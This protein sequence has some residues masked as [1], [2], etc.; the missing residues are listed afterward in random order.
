MCKSIRHH[1]ISRFRCQK[2]LIKNMHIRVRTLFLVCWEVRRHSAGRSCDCIPQIVSSAN[3]S[4]LPM[5]Y[6]GAGPRAVGERRVSNELWTGPRTSRILHF[7]CLWCILWGWCCAASVTD[8]D[9][10]TQCLKVKGE[11][12]RVGK[13]EKF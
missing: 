12:R 7:C 5:L 13:H 9:S 10:K 8:P 1:G 6:G 3:R 4:L 2:R 11:E